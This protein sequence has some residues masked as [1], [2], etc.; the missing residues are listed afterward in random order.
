[1]ASKSFS[2][3]K[4]LN[5]S[6]KCSGDFSLAEKGVTVTDS[7]S[8]VQVSNGCGRWMKELYD[9]QLKDDTII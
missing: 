3:L 8:E 2:K 5:F 7:C 9:K 6:S 4:C 1:M